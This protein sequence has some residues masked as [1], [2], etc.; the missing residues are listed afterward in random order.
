MTIESYDAQF[1]KILPL[2]EKIVLWRFKIIIRKPSDK[3]NFNSV[4]NHLAELS[5]RL[6]KQEEKKNG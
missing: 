4:C 1:H 3:V 5:G 6:S 2:K